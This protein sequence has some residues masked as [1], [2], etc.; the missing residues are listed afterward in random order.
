MNFFS[1]CTAPDAMVLERNAKK[2]GGRGSG[3]SLALNYN[4]IGTTTPTLRGLSRP[5]HSS[6]LD[7]TVQALTKQFH[8]REKWR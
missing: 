4:F 2:N 6:V 3:F 1:A 8:L 5:L 7:I